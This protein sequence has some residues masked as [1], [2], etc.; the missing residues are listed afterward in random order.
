MTFVTR[1]H[2]PRRSFL[3]GVGTAIALPFLDSMVPAFSRAADIKQ[4]AR[5][6]FLYVPNGIVMNQWTPATDGHP[7]PT[8][9]PSNRLPAPTRE[10]K[11]SALDAVAARNAKS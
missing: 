8:L 9:T 6:A 11:R 7:A 10:A 2:I 1:R 3:K 4:P 5:M